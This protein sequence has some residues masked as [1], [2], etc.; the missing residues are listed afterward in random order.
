MMRNPHHIPARN[1]TAV[2]NMMAT[3]NTSATAPN[4]VG[5]D[6]IK[7]INVSNMFIF[8]YAPTGTTVTI[9]LGIATFAIVFAPAT[10]INS[11]LVSGLAQ[12]IW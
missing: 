9:T 10:A 8:P 5:N 4:Q 1:V 6:L 7:A 2:M 3:T 12:P 11:I